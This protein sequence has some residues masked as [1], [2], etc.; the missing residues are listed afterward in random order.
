MRPNIEN[1]GGGETFLL[2]LSPS[3]VS[4]DTMHDN[5]V[6]ALLLI[7]PFVFVFQLGSVVLHESLSLQMPCLKVFKAK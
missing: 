3:H 5:S 4:C 7:L 1:F 6:D 2:H